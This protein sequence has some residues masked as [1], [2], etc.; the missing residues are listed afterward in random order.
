M[1][2]KPEYPLMQVSQIKQRRLE[3]AEKMLKE[4][5]E[6]LQKEEEALKVAIAKRDKVLEHR[7]EKLRK[8]L[9]EMDQG[10]SSEKILQAERYIKKVVDEDLKKEE[11][12]VKEQQEVVKKAE[13]AVEIARLDMVKRNQEVEKMRL[14]QADWEKEQSLIE[15]QAENLEMDELGS[16]TFVRKK[17]Q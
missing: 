8:H 13:K 3:E 11:K 17:K 9:A 1:K 10:T 2:K 14:H 7:K 12:K 4:R 15:M 16:S 5:K 6:Q